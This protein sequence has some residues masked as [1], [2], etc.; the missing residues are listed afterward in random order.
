MGLLISGD[1]ELNPG[2][3]QLPFAVLTQRLRTIGFRPLDLGGDGDCFLK[4]CHISCV[5]LQIVI[6]QFEMLVFSILGITQK[7]LL[8]AMLQI[9][10]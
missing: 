4:L 10:G 3:T 5:A 8:R 6:L 1:I 2:P 9:R 7:K